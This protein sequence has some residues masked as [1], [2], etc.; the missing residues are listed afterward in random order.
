MF[1]LPKIIDKALTP[2]IGGMF[3]DLK[4]WIKPSLK[5]EQKRKI[6]NY[7][8]NVFDPKT[9]TKEI[10]FDQMKFFE[11]LEDETL[12]LIVGWENVQDEYSEENKRTLINL[13]DE[14]TDQDI[15]VKDEEGKS[16]TRKARLFEYI[17]N[18]AS[19]IQNFRK[20]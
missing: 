8:D 18:F 4:L 14:L 1:L 17:V 19:N 12:S 11:K 7:S 13:A 15:E 16:I 20:N 6:L 10:V 5:E 2:E 9:H 3:G